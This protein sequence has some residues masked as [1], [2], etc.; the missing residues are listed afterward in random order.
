MEEPDLPQYATNEFAKQGWVDPEILKLQQV[1]H[2]SH[3]SG[4]TTC[5]LAQAGCSHCQ[6]SLLCFMQSDIAEF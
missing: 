6:T 1:L 3:V 4:G 2:V 5:V